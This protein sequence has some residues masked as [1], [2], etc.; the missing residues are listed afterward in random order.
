MA[1]ASI[2][3]NR[4]ATFD[5]QLKAAMPELRR[6]ARHM[7]NSGSDADDALNDAMEAVLTNWRSFREDGHFVRWCKLTIRSK[8]D[9]NRR[10][11]ARY[12]HVDIEEV[13]LVEDARQE[14][15]AEVYC[16]LRNVAGL[17]EGG[18]EV[19]LSALGHS[20]V[21]VGKMVG[22]TGPRVCQRLKAARAELRAAA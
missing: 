12:T 18:Q 21:A 14:G 16:T 4:P 17:K 19:I 5:A 9:W 3:N 15:A 22:V 13:E 7:T 2:N 20:Q 1:I 11:A 6:Y 8:A 10:I